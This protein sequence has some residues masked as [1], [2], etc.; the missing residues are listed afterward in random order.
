[1]PLD[2]DAAAILQRVRE[3]GV[4]PWRSLPPVEGRVV[5]R[6]RALLFDGPKLPAGEV[7]D[8]A[9]PSADGDI[10][11]RVYRPE[12][13]PRPI[14]IYLHGGGWT[15]G[16][17]DTHDAVCR[18]I[19]VASDCMVVSVA[20]RLAPEHRYQAQL[21]DVDAA[22]G[23]LAAQGDDL[24]G[25]PT[26]LAMGGDSAGGNL[27]AGASIRLRDAGGPRLA[28]QV[29]IYPATAPW[30]ETLSYHQ[31]AE[32]YW[33]TRKDVIWFWDNF[34]GPG[35]GAQDPYACPGIVEDLRDLPPAVV[36]TAGFDP[37]RD[38]GEVYA[39]R[40]RRAGVRVAAKRFPGMIHGFVALP[41]AIPAGDRAIA[42]IATAT[43]RAWAPTRP[44]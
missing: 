13:P 8:A 42:I 19:S 28:L 11:I 33:L 41:T 9:I 16:D 34:L 4:P 43:R 31:N 5:Y 23:W 40:L 6:N 30:F 7:W 38:E 24:G 21:D 35:D 20:Y 15:L 27:T 36:I 37:L 32:G 39:I 26:R 12:G 14:F 25:D 29:L 1:M 2:P 17:V 10:P 22:G 44:A 3:A 18:R